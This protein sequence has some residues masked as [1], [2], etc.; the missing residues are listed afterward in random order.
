MRCVDLL[1]VLWAG[2]QRQAV[3]AASVARQQSLRHW[4]PKLRRHWEP[5]DATARLHRWTAR[6][7]FPIGMM[8]TVEFVRGFL[9]RPPVTSGFASSSMELTLRSS[10]IRAQLVRMMCRRQRSN[11]RILGI[12]CAHDSNLCAVD[13]GQVVLHVEKERFTMRRHDVGS[14]EGFVPTGLQSIGLTIGHIDLVA[15]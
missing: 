5:T 9:V 2:R 11:M 4:R 3:L 13:E 7:R 1:K 10:T 14:V 8:T 12:S 15:T 6:F